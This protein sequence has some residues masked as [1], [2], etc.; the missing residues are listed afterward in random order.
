VLPIETSS[1]SFS[2]VVLA[3]EYQVSLA[4]ELAA[5]RRDGSEIP[6]DRRS[7]RETERYLASA[8]VEALRRNRE[9]ALRRVAGLLAVRVHDEVFE[10]VAP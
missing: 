7:L 9:E 1:T 6:L 5:R 8:D 10:L 3:L 2:S 4:L